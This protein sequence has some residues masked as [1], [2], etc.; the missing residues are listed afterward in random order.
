MQMQSACHCNNSDCPNCA[1]FPEQSFKNLFLITNLTILLLS[2]SHTSEWLRFPGLSHKLVLWKRFSLYASQK[3][4]PTSAVSSLEF[5]HMTHLSSTN[6]TPHFL[7]SESNIKKEK[8]YYWL[9]ILKNN[10]NENF[11]NMALGSTPQHSKSKNKVKSNWFVVKDLPRSKI[12]QGYYLL[13][14]CYK[15]L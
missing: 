9:T 4:P 2:T 11:I 14:M 12:S 15:L 5:S 7:F 1:D 8:L 3:L 6:K 10:I 13:W